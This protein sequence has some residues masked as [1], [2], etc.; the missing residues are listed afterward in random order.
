MNIVLLEIGRRLSARRKQMNM[1]QDALAEKAN[2]T[3]QT[4]SYAELG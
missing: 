2:V 1:T 3:A 4:I